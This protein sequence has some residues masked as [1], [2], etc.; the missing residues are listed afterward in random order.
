V[1]QASITLV[2]SRWSVSAWALLRSGGERQL[3]TGGVLGGSQAGMRATYR[4]RDGLAVSGRAYAP[5]DTPEGAEVALGIE[6][7]PLR[8]VPVRVLAERRQGIGKEGR[9]AFALLA[10]GAVSDQPLIGPVTLDAYAQAGVVGARSRDGFIDGAVRLGAPVAGGLSAGV[11]AWGAAQPGVSRFDV[12]PQVSY[13]LPVPGA[14]MRVSAE[15]RFRVGG[16]AR[17]GSGPA[18]TLS[19]DF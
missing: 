19:T 9:S 8:T 15:W 2:P 7:Q 1:G 12:G 6:W 3:A 11:G 16:D 14:T 13:R 5:I 18:L 17:P 4:L 10:Y